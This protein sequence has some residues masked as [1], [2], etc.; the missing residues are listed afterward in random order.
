MI[1]CGS[2]EVKCLHGLYYL[3]F[4]A[5]FKICLCLLVNV[6]CACP[7]SPSVIQSLLM[8]TSYVLHYSKKRS[9]LREHNLPAEIVLLS[10]SCTIYMHS[11]VTVSIYLNKVIPG[12]EMQ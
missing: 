6:P 11:K 5:Y 7:K 2:L 12:V 3:S 9:P 10:I 1:C 8:D 4:Q